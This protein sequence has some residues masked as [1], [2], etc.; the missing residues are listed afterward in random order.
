MRK[1]AV[2]ALIV[3]CGSSVSTAETPLED[4]A[5]ATE[6]APGDDT[7]FVED[8]TP[9]SLPA[10]AVETIVDEDASPGTPPDMTP[11]SMSFPLGV[12]T[13]DATSDRVVAWANYTGAG[14]LSFVAWKMSGTSFVKELP[15]VPVKA[16]EG[17]VLADV[18][19]LEAGARY[20][21]AFFEMEGTTRKARSPIGSFRAALAPGSKE[22]L[23]FGATSCIHQGKTLKTLEQA[24]S[25]GYDA[26][27]LLGDSTYND[28]AVSVPEYRTKWGENLK[29]P[30]Y[31]QL[32]ASTSIIATWDDHEVDN[33]WS[34]DNQP[35]EKRT[36]ATKVFYEMTPV[37]RN[38]TDPNRLWR[39]LKWGDTAE[40]FVL[41]SR[42]E[43]KP[44]T[45]TTAEAEYISK[46]QQAWLEDSLKKSTATFKL[47]LNSVP[48]TNFPGAFDFASKDR[49]EGYAAQRTAVLRSIEDN[50]ITGVF[51]LSGDFHLAAM[52]RVSTSGVG[53]GQLEA[54]V[55]P[56][57]N[58]GNALAFS[59]NK[60]QFDWAGSTSN[61][62]A[63]ALD[64]ATRT[65]K[66][67]WIDGAGKT[68][69]EGSYKL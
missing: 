33:D 5:N 42:S 13:G 16:V 49:W 32:R 26:F 57:D 40:V 35:L 66:L 51:W 45:R 41:D 14:M 18:L 30:F 20:R 2:L 58:N 55:G 50:K 22:P 69:F 65:I 39:T 3:G 11:P 38:T 36:N 23:T 21:Y 56:G 31:Q 8:S 48:I 29:V 54:L 19:G 6:T 4:S 27:F 63:I 25:K 52:A 1:V 28:G 44:A 12:A 64:P 7:A 34:G 17:F 67:T 15:A 60:P 53:A 59:L 9:D 10:D 37:M 24:A 43:R 61:T 46:A 62:T 47:I 68:L